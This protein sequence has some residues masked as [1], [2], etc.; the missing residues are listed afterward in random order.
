LVVPIAVVIIGL[1][2]LVFTESL[3]MPYVMTADQMSR[4]Y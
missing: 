3:M 1:F 2:V 4:N